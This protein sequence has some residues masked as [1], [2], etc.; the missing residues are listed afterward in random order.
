MPSAVF[1][2][3]TPTAKQLQTHVLDRKAT[4]IG[5]SNTYSLTKQLRREDAI[6]GTRACVLN[7]PS[8]SHFISIHII[9]LS[10]KSRREQQ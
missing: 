6:H 2:P 3:A 1:E 7:Q 8:S 5:E 9:R 4:V 10:A